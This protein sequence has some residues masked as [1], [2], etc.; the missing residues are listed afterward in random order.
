M[1]ESEAVERNARVNAEALRRAGG[2]REGSGGVVEAQ[3]KI[4]AKALEESRA[5][6]TQ[7]DAQQFLGYTQAESAP[8]APAPP[9]QLNLSTM[10]MTPSAAP[11]APVSKSGVSRTSGGLSGVDAICG[12]GEKGR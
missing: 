12:H 6:N 11:A 10:S 9:A 2:R 4:H 8:A 7:D 1:S 5:R 3:A